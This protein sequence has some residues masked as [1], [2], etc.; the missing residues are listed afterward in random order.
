MNWHHEITG[1]ARGLEEA[2]VLS[3]SRYGVCAVM[4]LIWPP[5]GFARD[6]IGLAGDRKGYM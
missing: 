6:N 3:E 5:I 4:F 2:L 1:I